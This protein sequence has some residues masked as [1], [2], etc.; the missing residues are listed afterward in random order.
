VSPKVLAWEPIRFTSL[1]LA[2]EGRVV[3][4]KFKL[5]DDQQTPSRVF[6][7]LLSFLLA[8]FSRFAALRDE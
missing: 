2:G 3:E 4:G 8:F 5:G 6:F 7:A 1:F